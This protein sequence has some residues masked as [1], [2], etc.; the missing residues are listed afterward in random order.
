MSNRVARI[1]AALRAHFAPTILQVQDDSAMHA[2]HSGA[3]AEGETHYNVLVVSERFSGLN[4]V[5]RHRLINAALSDE[6]TA[7]LHALSLTLR[8][9]G[10]A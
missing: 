1:E 7:G 5:A 9:P 10:E 2:G 8:A 4:R 3:R 6:F